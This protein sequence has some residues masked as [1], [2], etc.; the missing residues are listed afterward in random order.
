[1]RPAPAGPNCT[2]VYGPVGDPAAV[3]AAARANS[4]IASGHLDT[5]V[6]RV[7]PGQ[8]ALRLN[9]PGWLRLTPQ[10]AGDLGTHA[11]RVAFCAEAL[12]DR[13]PLFARPLRV[14]MARYMAFLETLAEERREDWQARIAAIGLARC[15]AIVDYRD[16]LFSGF[17]PLPNAWLA[18]D[19]AAGEAVAMVR[20]DCAFWTGERLIGV[21]TEGSSMPTPRQALALAELESSSALVEIVRLPAHWLQSGPELGQFMTARLAGF[22]DDGMLTKGLFRL[23]RLASAAWVGA[24]VE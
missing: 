15:D 21:L 2:I 10:S 13:V 17:L 9:S 22:P 1:M 14:F 23:R 18:L 3:L 4:A 24:Q 5:F 11:A 7:G 20:V 19:D 6:A 12:R 8:P 16:W